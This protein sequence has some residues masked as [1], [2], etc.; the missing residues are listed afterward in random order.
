M[1]AGGARR[2][3]EGVAGAAAVAFF[4][5][6]MASPAFFVG[7]RQGVDVK[8]DRT[9]LQEGFAEQLAHLGYEIVQLQ[10][11]GNAQRPVVRLRVEHEPPN[12]PVSLD[13]CARVSRRLEA[14]IDEGARLPERYVLEVSSPGMDRPLT[15]D[16]DFQRFRGRRVAVR[17][18]QVLCGRASRL[19]GELLGLAGGGDGSAIRLRLNEGDEVEVP[20]TAV[21][22]VRLEQDWSQVIR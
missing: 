13:D 11:A 19:E 1:T 3:I 2:Y 12:R 20:R 15:R 22:D 7:S 4:E 6:G 14:W 21:R 16:R 17:G 8:T 10:W 18:T 5:W 9:G